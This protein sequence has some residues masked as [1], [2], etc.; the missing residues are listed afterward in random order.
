M[1][2]SHVYGSIGKWYLAKLKAAPFLTNL[3]TGVVLMTGS[4]VLVQKVESRQSLAP[5]SSMTQSSD[6]CSCDSVETKEVSRRSLDHEEIIGISSEE[7]LMIYATDS[8]VGARLLDRHEA[9]VDTIKDE[10]SFWNPFRTGT[11]ASWAFLYVPFYATVYKAYDRYLPKKTP[12]GILARVALSFGTSVPVNAAFYTYGTTIEHTQAWYGELR[13][14]QRENAFSYVPYHFD[15]LWNKVSWKL[16][17]ELPTTIQA[18]ATCWMPF[19]VLMFSVVPSHMQPLSL[20]VFSFFWNCYLSMSQH[21][22]SL[23]AAESMSQEKD[24]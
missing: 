22:S 24:E 10:L 21:R 15:R 12:V 6:C 14:N 2:A 19:N 18:S 3:S 20:M 13:R 5:S 17:N 11:M 1:V 23:A 4:D 9:V 8:V 7:D 16:Q